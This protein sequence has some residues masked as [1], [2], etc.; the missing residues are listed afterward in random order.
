MVESRF[1][2]TELHDNRACRKVPPALP[3]LRRRAAQRPQILRKN[4]QRE[5][6]I[7]VVGG[8]GHQRNGRVILDRA[9]QRLRIA[10]EAQHARVGGRV[11]FARKILRDAQQNILADARKPRIGVSLGFDG[12][13]QLVA[14]ARYFGGG[15]ETVLQ[16]FL[17]AGNPMKL[18]GGHGTQAIEQRFCQRVFDVDI[19]ALLRRLEQLL[20]GHS[21]KRRVQLAA[22]KRCTDGRR[23]GKR[24]ECTVV[25]AASLACNGN[26]LNIGRQGL[27]IFDGQR[28]IGQGQRFAQSIQRINLLRGQR[29]GAGIG[30]PF[31]LSG[32]LSAFTSIMGSTRET[33]VR[34]A[35]CSW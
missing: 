27:Q 30:R 11:V 20:A 14:R 23:A 21:V 24:A 25:I 5:E 26:A 3:K 19:A 15:E 2:Q 1:V 13:N 6:W 10:S 31:L 12:K 8:L 29:A 22:R 32:N 34:N 33:G 35:F 9:Q 4:I 7:G 18:T 16:P 17:H 28:R